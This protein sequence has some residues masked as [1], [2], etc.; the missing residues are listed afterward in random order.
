MQ[1]KIVSFRHYL[2]LH[3][4]E[5]KSYSQYCKEKKFDCFTTDLDIPRGITWQFRFLLLDFIAN[6]SLF[7]E[8]N[9]KVTD[10]REMETQEKNN[11]LNFDL[12]KK[13]FSQHKSTEY[14]Q[15]KRYVTI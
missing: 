11:S 14:E 6:I 2:W 12:I 15:D 9:N 7:K 1:N 3:Q 5:H 10:F 8:M 13:I 4:K